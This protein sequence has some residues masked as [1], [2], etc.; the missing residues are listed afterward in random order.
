MDSI[1]VNRNPS[2]DNALAKKNSLDDSLGGNSTLS[3]NQTLENCIK[4]SVG[5]D[6]YNLSKHDKKQIM[7]TTIS[8]TGKSGTDILP[9]WKIVSNEENLGVKCRNFVDPTKRLRQQAIQ[10]QLFYLLLVTILY[11]LEIQ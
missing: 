9:Y 3:F 4:V 11:I 8:K 7:D 1:T 6:V 2:S 5:S 10:D